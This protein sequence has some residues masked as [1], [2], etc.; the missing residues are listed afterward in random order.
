MT[1]IERAGGW[2]G[3]STPPEPLALRYGELDDQVGDLHLPAAGHPPQ[4]PVVALLHGGFWRMPYGRDPLDALARD[5]ARRGFAAW[6][7]EYRRLG[8]PGAGW[9]GTF[10]DVAAGL[11]RLAQRVASAPDLD[12]ERVAVVGHSAGGQLALWA[13][14]RG[15]L[16]GDAPGAD[17]RLR[18]AA[19]AALAPLADLERV[20]RERL[21]G[22]AVAELLG[23][24][25]EQVPERYRA[26]SPHA[27]LPLGLPQLLLHGTSDAEVP[28][29]H[30]RDYARAARA[31][32]DP[33][34]FRELPGGGHMDF[35]D[36]AGAAHSILC[37]WLAL[38]LR[39]FP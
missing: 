18:P 37:E 3:E 13:A 9:P 6:N 8:A 38:T 15:R 4:V 29:D 5:L 14:A 31:A 19:V 36:P 7:L 30:A 35:L 17:P 33:I 2:S 23:G 12:L 28:I 10:A 26:A 24:T 27:R 11:D 22:S 20:H 39:L 1:G 25:P 21:G 16:P 34:D 32:G